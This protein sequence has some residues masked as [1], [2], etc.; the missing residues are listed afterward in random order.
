M[1]CTPRTQPTI[2]AWFAQQ[3]EIQPDLN[4]NLLPRYIGFTK[5]GSFLGTSELVAKTMPGWGCWGFWLASSSIHE[6]KLPHSL[7]SL[8]AGVWA[9]WKLVESGGGLQAAGNSVHLSCQGSGFNFR[10]YH[11]LWYRQAPFGRIEWVSFINAFGNTKDYG[12]AVE[13]RANVSRDNSQSKAYLSLHALLSQ[14]SARYFS[15]VHT[16][17]GNSAAL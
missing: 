14:D 15:A 4:I 5:S 17:T 7:C 12:K 1:A 2:S 8:S 6:H 3:Q 11:V 16:G 10:S 13:G 9:Q